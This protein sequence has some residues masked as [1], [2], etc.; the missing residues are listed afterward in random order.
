MIVERELNNA[1]YCTISI[2]SEDPCDRDIFDVFGISV[3]GTVTRDK[4]KFSVGPEKK[5][6]MTMKL[7]CR[8]RQA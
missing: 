1:S 6:D 2:Y 8:I 7:L 4:V 5:C 3:E